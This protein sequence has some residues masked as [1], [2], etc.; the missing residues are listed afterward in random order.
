M[1]GINVETEVN[2]VY[3]GVRDD[4]N[5]GGGDIGV[6]GLTAASFERGRWDPLTRTWTGPSGKIIHRFV[7][8]STPAEWA[9][10]TGLD[11][12]G[13]QIDTSNTASITH[14]D[15]AL[16]G[17]ESPVYVPGCTVDV[18]TS[19]TG[20]AIIRVDAEVMVPAN[21]FLSRSK[22]LTVNANAVGPNATPSY[23]YIGVNGTVVDATK[24]DIFEEYVSH[25]PNTFPSEDQPH[26]S[27][28][29]KRVE[30]PVMYR[31][32]CTLFHVAITAAGKNSFGLMIDP[33][34]D[35]VFVGV[36]SVSV[37]LGNT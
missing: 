25:A 33:R 5:G 22:R 1:S 27:A 13:D 21:S 34:S 28:S 36:R 26:A 2:K 29:V 3:R 17:Q 19:H 7:N 18:T 9:M 32:R 6:A 35:R 23:A 15:W 10:L 37:E 8:P 12:S 4:L 11:K 24:T 16:W 20:Y 14:T 30:D 31:R